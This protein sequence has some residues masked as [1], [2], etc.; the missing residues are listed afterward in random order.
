MAMKSERMAAN[1]HQLGKS[2]EEMEAIAASRATAD[3]VQVAE[4]AKTM[5]RLSRL[6]AEAGATDVAEGAAALA[7]SEDIEVQS[8]VVRALG[9]DDLQRG[10][11]L[12]A[13]A[14]QL[15]VA[16]E[17]VAARD[18]PVFAAFLEDTGERLH[19]LAVDAIVR[20]GAARALAKAMAATGAKIGEFAANEVA[21]GL[22][23][24]A[25]SDAA[26]ERSGEFAALGAEA[27][28]RG[29]A[30]PESMR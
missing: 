11:G 10:R 19:D 13:I 3:A 8:S 23:R 7:A 15:A 2:A 27:A 29:A 1:R 17:A 14:G 26:A 16:S 9:A 21:E 18:M 28:A 30:K 22:V 20:A 4:G 5:T 6:V 12:G 25:A 24:L